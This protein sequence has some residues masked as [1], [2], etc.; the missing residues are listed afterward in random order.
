MNVQKQ[1]LWLKKSILKEQ[2]FIE[3]LSKL[4]H[5]LIVSLGVSVDA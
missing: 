5:V 2:S 4:Y 3:V 1:P